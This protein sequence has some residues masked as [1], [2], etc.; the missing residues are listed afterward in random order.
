[1]RTQVRSIITKP[2]ML[3]PTGSPRGRTEVF[4]V[5]SIGE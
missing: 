1:M 4:D 2:N 3:R 5:Q